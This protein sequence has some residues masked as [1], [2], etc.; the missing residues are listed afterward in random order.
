MRFKKIIGIRKKKDLEKEK[1]EK[2]SKK[3][4]IKNK[5][6]K[7]GWNHIRIGYKYGLVLFIVGIFFLT[8]TFVTIQALNDIKENIDTL[9]QVGKSALD[10]TKMG[11]LFREKDAKIGEYIFF[12]KDRYLDDYKKVDQEFQQSVEDVKLIIKDIESFVDVDE[13]KFLYTHI[14]SN[15]EKMDDILQK[16]IIPAIKEND[17][18]KVIEPKITTASLRQRTI[19]LLE[20][21]RE[22]VQETR[23]KAIEEAHTSMKRATF[24]LMISVA[25]SIVLGSII[26]IIIGRMIRKNLDKVIHVSDEAAK[27]N[28]LVEKIDY[29]GKDEIGKLS[30]SIN[31]MVG[32]LRDMMKDVMNVSNEANNQT[33]AFGNISE[34][35]RRGSEQIAATMQQM[36]VG[37]EEQANSATEIA[38]AVNQLGKLIEQTHE[39]GEELDQSTREVL[40]IAQVGNQQI[41]AS[42]DQIYVINDVVK[43]SVNKVQRLNEK[44]QNI[45]QLVEV[46]NQISDQTNLLA[47]NAAIE[48]A[49]AGEA[50]RGFAV[51]S[52][53]I[54][55]LA[56]Q[57][58]DSATEI[59]GIIEG[60]QEESQDMTKSL[61]DG[62]KQVETG[63]EQIKNTEKSFQQINNKVEDMVL[64]IEKVSQNL[65]KVSEHSLE[66]TSSVEQV[67]GIAEENSASIEQTSALAQE[68]NSAMDLMKEENDKMIS[69]IEKLRHSM[70]KF[71]I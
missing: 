18:R 10:I 35:V 30:A 43:D 21:M 46:I 65:D 70:S 8:S 23:G 22:I 56:E 52:D 54:R 47:L 26:M 63:T 24:I 37:A 66:I 67:A 19:L 28:L 6:A 5:F 59:R 2:N 58:G 33:E 29:E 15:D 62:Y 27:G 53:E 16:D 71:K 68:E 34:E 40:D 39:K 42:V 20:K 55:K 51:V 44:A 36:A 12:K 14:Q 9:D 11:S 31:Q 45:S 41:L 50:G 13:L 38:H 64:R 4:H 17:D 61:Q 25:L 57:V 48:A 32:N 3:L 7:F 49:R 1:Q 60:I 69:L